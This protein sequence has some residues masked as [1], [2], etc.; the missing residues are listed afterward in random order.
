[1]HLKHHTRCRSTRR[2]QS[3]EFTSKHTELMPASV[4]SGVRHS[5]RLTEFDRHPDGSTEKLRGTS[6]KVNKIRRPLPDGA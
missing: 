4:G 2:E 6:A 3:D 1:M 5:H